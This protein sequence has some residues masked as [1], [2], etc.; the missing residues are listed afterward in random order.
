MWFLNKN[1]GGEI[2][3]LLNLSQWQEAV[4]QPPPPH[5][6]LTSPKAESQV[7]MWR[8]D[9]HEESSQ[10]WSDGG[11][12]RDN[13]RGDKSLFKSAKKLA[14]TGKNLGGSAG[15]HTIWWRTH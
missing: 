12:K 7:K 10:L 1:K 15:L 8:C 4:R 11:Y 9:D 14:A 6:H 2:F 3:G 5:L 13:L